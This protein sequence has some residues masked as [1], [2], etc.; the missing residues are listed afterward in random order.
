MCSAT[1]SAAAE[2]VPVER[3]DISCRDDSTCMAE[4]GGAGGCFGRQ[5]VSP[6]WSAV[7]ALLE[8]DYGGTVR[9][10]R[11]SAS[12]RLIGGIV[13]PPRP[14]PGVIRS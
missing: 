14:C 11:I 6:C 1:R 12:A 2:I 5:T 8:R 3:M 13:L 4:R 10:R 9:K 7:R